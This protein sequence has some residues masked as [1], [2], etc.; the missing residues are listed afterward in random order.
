[1]MTANAS[2]QAA[3]DSVTGRRS[4][5]AAATERLSRIDCPRSPRSTR[6]YQSIICSGSCLSSP[7]STRSRATCSGVALASRNAD[8]GSPGT[9]QISAKVMSETSSNTTAAPANRLSKNRPIRGSRGVSGFEPGPPHARNPVGREVLQ[10]DRRGLEDPVV[11]SLHDHG[12]VVEVLLELVEQGLALA[13]VG[14]A[15]ESRRDL[16]DLGILRAAE[17][18]ARD[19]R[20]H[21]R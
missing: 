10:L 3:S 5:S 4:T 20:G 6:P 16:V 9:S 15:G 21:H 8:A 2:A 18:Q 7:S 14:L 1:M 11:A 17:R 13:L 12:I 19:P